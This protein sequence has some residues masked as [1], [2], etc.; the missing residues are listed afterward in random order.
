MLSTLYQFVF[1]IFI[2]K[3]NIKIE[4]IIVTLTLFNS[5]SRK[6]IGSLSC[7]EALVLIYKCIIFLP[8]SS[9]KSVTNSS[10]V[11]LINLNSK[12]G[13]N[14]AKTLFYAVRCFS[15]NRFL[16]IEMFTSINCSLFHQISSK[17]FHVWYANKAKLSQI[18]LQAFAASSTC[19][20]AGNK[21][22]FKHQLVQRI[23]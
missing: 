11:L 8:N 21:R 14:N 12:I 15:H 5:Q 22:T 13:W 17:L 10:S 4:R 20:P 3:N 18:A 6:S 23:S 2:L 16:K 9:S 19:K 1:I 7:A